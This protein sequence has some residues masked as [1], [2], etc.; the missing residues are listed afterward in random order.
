MIKRS[1][2]FSRTF[3]E[4]FSGKFL[5]VLAI[6]VLP[7]LLAF[8]LTPFPSGAV[9]SPRADGSDRPAPT[10]LTLG[11]LLGLG[12]LWLW[13]KGRRDRVTPPALSAVS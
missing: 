7:C 11:F 12:A 6:V 1:H 5:R 9:D 3:W 4:L 10:Y 13:G 2:P 8:F